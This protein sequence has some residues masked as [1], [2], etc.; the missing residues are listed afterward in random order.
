MALLKR[1]ERRLDGYVLSLVPHWADADDILQDVVIDLWRQFDNYDPQGDF[2]AWACTLAY[3]RVLTYR[4]RTK[5]SQIRFSD[6]VDRLLTQELVTVSKEV[7]DHLD[8]LKRC[9]EKLSDSQRGLLQAYYS[10]APIVELA[11][12]FARSVASLYK[13][14]SGLRRVL[15][16]CVDHAVMDEKEKLS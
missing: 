10:G 16:A 6:D 13:D 14:L 8:V 7:N 3:Y 2:G 5:R 11:R 15:R 12:R 9:L 4:K 1:H